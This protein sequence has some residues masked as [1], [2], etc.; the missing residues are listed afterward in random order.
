[1]LGKLSVR[2]C[3]GGREEWR[4]GGLSYLCREHATRLCCQNKGGATVL[5][6]VGERV[7]TQVHQP[8]IHTV[9]DKAV[10]LREGGREGGNLQR[11]D[12]RTIR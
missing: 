12:L 7:A 5:E 9:V 4:K 6:A 10:H 3:Q 2:A 1:M 8:H 11:Q